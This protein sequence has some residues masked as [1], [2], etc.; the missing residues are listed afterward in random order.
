MLPQGRSDSKDARTLR[1]AAQAP[2]QSALATVAPAENSR[3]GRLS[4]GI[5]VEAPVVPTWAAGLLADLH[6]DKRMVLQIV[7]LAPARPPETTRGRGLRDRAAYAVFKL[8]ERA[9]RL[10]F[11]RDWRLSEHTDLRRHLPG[12]PIVSAEQ[13]T[14]D[15]E[16]VAEPL[17]VLFT[18]GFVNVPA[19]LAESA[20]Y[21]VWSLECGEAEFAAMNL[22]LFWTVYAGRP[23][24]SITLRASTPTRAHVLYTSQTAATPI[25]LHRN[26]E[27]ATRKGAYYVSRRLIEVKER[28]LAA[29][30]AS[31][32][33]ARA[34]PGADWPMP[35]P[36]QTIV[37]VGKVA[38][39]VF[40]RQ[41]HRR[42]Q[43]ERWVIAYR[44]LPAGVE[45]GQ[46]FDGF[47]VLTPPPGH[48]FMDPFLYCF[49]GAR[50]IFFEDFEDRAG[51]AVI[52]YVVIDE[53]GRASEPR[54]AL[55]RP[56]HV[57]YPCVFEWNGDIYMVP[58]TTANRTIELYRSDAFPDRWILDRVL[59]R[60][61]L[62]ADSTVFVQDD[63]LWLFT[64]LAIPRTAG[65]DE[66]CVFS[67]DS[68]DGE[69]VEH[70]MNPVVADH[71]RARP[72]GYIFSRNGDLIRPAQ[73]GRH[74]YGSGVVFNRIERLSETEYREVPIGRFDG[75][76]IAENIGTHTYSFDGTFEAV[77]ARRLHPKLRPTRRR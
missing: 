25:S 10:L 46:A 53:D 27:V 40:T 31:N 15:A 56:H 37:C 63:R 68:L 75:G 71:A 22:A 39:R 12:V 7:L 52:S 5:V 48:S 76:S 47:Q 32:P 58:E 4:I 50:Y 73:D 8:Y 72:A 2:D 70:P 34:F 18:L 3:N 23:T 13:S 9:D 38:R 16:S 51:K 17:D 26:R 54:V 77:D 19:P 61:V 6:R 64:S 30:A 69:W 41:N 43:R 55:H 21:G 42:M 60:D 59:V 57:S 62:A 74:R 24:F 44:R 14:D 35:S 67:A 66:L 36:S 20:R 29:V 45:P 28:G 11:G 49:E 65:D 1:A 33:G